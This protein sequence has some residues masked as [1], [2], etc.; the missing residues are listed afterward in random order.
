[1]PWLLYLTG[2]LAVNIKPYSSC[3]ELCEADLYCYRWFCYWPLHCLL[4]HMGQLQTTKTKSLKSQRTSL[5]YRSPNPWVE[6]SLIDRSETGQGNVRVTAITNSLG[7]LDTWQRQIGAIDRQAPAGPGER[8][9]H[10]ETTST[11]TDHRTFWVNSSLLPKLIQVPGVVALLD[12]ENSP[13]PY[14]ILPIEPS[15][16][17]VRS[18]DIHGAIDAWEM[19]FSGEGLI[20]AVADTGVDFAHPDLNGTQARVGFQNSSYYGWPL[21]FDHNSMYTW[22]VDGRPTLSQILGMPIHPRRF[23]Q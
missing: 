15:P 7:H 16:N 5:E 11:G 6:Q 22:M 12:A 8:F 10:H 14:G 19:G 9:S 21:M 18:G 2:R 23:R 20:V 13:E 4:W 1:M 3:R 17:T